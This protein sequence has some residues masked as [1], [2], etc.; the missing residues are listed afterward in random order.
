MASS[1]RRQ[2]IRRARQSKW[3]YSKNRSRLIHTISRLECAYCGIHLSVDEATLDHVVPKAK[4]GDHSK[5]N[6]V[7]SCE[8]CNGRKKSLLL[9]DF[10]IYYSAKFL[11]YATNPNRTFCLSVATEH[12]RG[13]VGRLAMVEVL[14]RNGL[15]CDSDV[16]DAVMWYW[17]T[18]TRSPD[19]KEQLSD[20]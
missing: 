16:E 12:W 4:G 20:G 18:P 3:W 9:P 5:R 19:T 15:A 14:R 13:D 6:L 1:T 2:S 10:P 7:P 17:R 8:K 11:R